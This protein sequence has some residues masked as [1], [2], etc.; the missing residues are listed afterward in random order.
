MKN[1]EV[2]EAMLKSTSNPNSIKPSQPNQP[3]Q[4]VHQ[5]NHGPQYA[6]R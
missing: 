2:L 1:K 3:N 6:N 5:V 4:P